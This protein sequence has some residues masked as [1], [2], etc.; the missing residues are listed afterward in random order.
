MKTI[1][2]LGFSLVMLC[3]GLLFIGKAGLNTYRYLGSSNWER[4][5][6]LI[7]SSEIRTGRDGVARSGIRAKVRRALTLYE[8]QV[9]YRYEY[10]G[11]A[12]TGHRV[13]LGSRRSSDAKAH[14]KLKRRFDQLQAEQRQI[15]AWVN[16][17]S[18]EEAVLYRTHNW[19][20]TAS[21]ALFGLFGLG[22]AGGVVA[23]EL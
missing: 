21:M 16:P 14:R 4:A 2:A 5:P 20:V 8:T 17:T 23:S 7:E 15:Y 12:Y 1:A 10:D 13:D 3:V 22:I 6:A 19:V 11:K 9:T 18:P